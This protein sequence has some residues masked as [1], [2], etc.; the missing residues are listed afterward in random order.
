MAENNKPPSG[1]SNP[2][3]PPEKKPI[4]NPKVDVRVQPLK[5]ADKDYA[6]KVRRNLKSDVEK[7]VKENEGGGSRKQLD[8]AEKTTK[9]AGTK[10]DPSKVKEISVDVSGKVGKT[11]VGEETVV[12]PG[13]TPEG[14]PAPAPAAPPAKKD[15]TKK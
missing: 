10:I 6:E 2:E 3:V 15:G 8:A 11:K 9:E 12:K 14:P 1:P 13:P 4:E 7:T 5:K